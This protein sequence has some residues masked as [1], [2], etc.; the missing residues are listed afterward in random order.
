MTK[1]FVV[2][3]RD[4]DAERL[5]GVAKELGWTK[6]RLVR[7]LV[8]ER[9]DDRQTVLDA[10]ERRLFVAALQ[11]LRRQGANLNQIA[12]CLNCY[13]RGLDRPSIMVFLNDADA[14][15]AITAAKEAVQKIKDLLAIDRRG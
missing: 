7:S 11:E 6:T 2:R 1:G 12:F 15:V 14:K 8:R 9:I 10:G 5:A 4:D 13:T 3:L